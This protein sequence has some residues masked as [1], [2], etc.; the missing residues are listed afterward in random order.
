MADY[1]KQ[2]TRD[3]ELMLADELA[4]IATLI[5]QA[6]QSSQAA[7][8]EISTWADASHRALQTP[9]SRERHLMAAQ[10]GAT[11]TGTSG[12]RTAGLNE[13]GRQHLAAENE[14]T[15]S[16]T[17]RMM[18]IAEQLDMALNEAAN[19]RT[20][21]A[22]K[23]TLLIGQLADKYKQDAEAMELARLDAQLKAS[24]Q[25]LEREKFEFEKDVYN[26][27]AGQANDLEFR[28]A[29]GPAAAKLGAEVRAGELSMDDAWEQMV[30]IAGQ[31]GMDL[32][33]AELRNRYK[34]LLPSVFTAVP[35][36]SSKTPQF[37]TTHFKNETYGSSAADIL[38]NLLQSLGLAT[39]LGQGYSGIRSAFSTPVGQPFR[40]AEDY[41]DLFSKIWAD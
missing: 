41:R 16:A 9:Y 25:S 39:P 22:R 26:K 21:V 17:N 40:P 35:S 34:T 33:P 6:Q 15:S 24:A 27:E 31:F 7:K 28:R 19:A 3:A 23:K 29:F 1:M 13:L 30:S 11:N 20:T 8:R 10:A 2:A 12:F 36:A 32:T 37:A 5:S 18:T 38:L 4:A 14:I